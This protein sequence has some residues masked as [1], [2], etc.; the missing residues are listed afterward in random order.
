[1]KRTVKIIMIVLLCIVALPVAAAAAVYTYDISIGIFNPYK[2]REDEWTMRKVHNSSK[3]FDFLANGLTSWDL[4]GDGYADIYLTQYE[5][6]GNIYVIE[7]PE[8]PLTAKEWPSV[9]VGTLKNAESSCFGDLDGDGYP[10]VLVSQGVEG[11]T[12]PSSIFVF[13][14]NRDSD[15]WESLGQIPA[16]VSEGHIHFLR[17][18]D[19]NNNGQADIIAGGRGNTGAGSKNKFDG[20]DYAGLVVLSLEGR[21]FALDNYVSTPVD[22]ALESG[23]GFVVADIDL[24]GW[25]DIAVCNSDFDTPPE[26]MGVFIYMNNA[27]GTFRKEKIYADNTLY[28][29]EQVDIGD[30][31]GDGRNEIVLH[32]K[33]DI[34]VF[35]RG[36]NGFDTLTV[37]K[38][39]YAVNRARLIK[40]ADIDGDGRLD[41]VGALIHDN[42]MLKRDKA[43][44]FV[45]YNRGDYA[46]EPRV[47]KWADGFR[48]FGEFNGEK[49]DLCIIDDVD[50]DGDADIV[51]N[52]EE[53]NRLTNILSVVWFEND[54]ADDSH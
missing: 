13:R 2:T 22:T 42:G 8:D 10:E 49:W 21:E 14:F 41:M 32:R 20:I 26:Q 9:R 33:E 52:C 34:K 16:S 5:F 53:Y 43:A 48:G 4:N 12:D 24:D 6:L 7:R 35:V 39:P 28:S 15:T 38:P 29:K 19:M 37:P 31:N 45:L 25:L 44:V 36:H 17:C 27:D 50:R 11:N 18:A 30:V 40:L 3:P 46:F 1:M 23:H 51:A 54:A 47:V